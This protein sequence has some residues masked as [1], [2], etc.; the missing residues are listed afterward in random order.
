MLIRTLHKLR[1]QIPTHGEEATKRFRSPLLLKSP[2]NTLQPDEQV[3]EIMRR[4]AKNLQSA[5]NPAQLEMRILAN[6]GADKRFAFLRGRWSRSWASMK[7]HSKDAKAKTPALGALANYSDSD[8]N[9][10]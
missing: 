3:K 1:L 7:H 6:F 4:T 2:A 8:D 9:S 5:S 10:S